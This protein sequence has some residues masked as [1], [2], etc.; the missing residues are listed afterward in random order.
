MLQG[1]ERDALVIPVTREFL[2]CD[3]VQGPTKRLEVRYSYGNPTVLNTTRQEYGRLVLPEDS[4]LQAR[5]NN[6]DDLQKKALENELSVLKVQLNSAA[7]LIVPVNFGSQDKPARRGTYPGFLLSNDGRSIAYDISMPPF[8]VGK[9]SVEL[10]QVPR[11]EVGKTEP[12]WISMRSG[13][14]GNADLRAHLVEVQ[15]ATGTLGDPVLFK[16]IYRDADQNWFASICEV[17]IGLHGVD[18]RY[19]QR[20]PYTIRTSGPDPATEAH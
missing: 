2:K 9:W 13:N 20:E 3:P 18:V 6:G 11:L 1:L 16:I 15:Q 10:D 7:P 17:S 12:T 5:A 14:T 8:K 4:L 19:C